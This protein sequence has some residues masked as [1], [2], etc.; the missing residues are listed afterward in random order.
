MVGRMI[1]GI[2]AVLLFLP[3]CSWAQVSTSPGNYSRLIVKRTLFQPGL[4]L[5]VQGKYFDVFYSKPYGLK[6]L[7]TVNGTIIIPGKDYYNG[8][9]IK[10]FGGG[11]YSELETTVLGVYKISRFFGICTDL[12]YT[13]LE[14]KGYK[15]RNNLTYSGGGCL[16]GGTFQI[17]VM[18]RNLT[19]MGAG[20]LEERQKG[21][22]ISGKMLLTENILFLLG[23]LNEES[24]RTVFSFES[25]LSI[26]A[27]LAVSCGIGSNPGEYLLGLEIMGKEM[28]LTYYYRDHTDLGGTFELGI[29]IILK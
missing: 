27:K 13:R 26:T 15:D 3:V 8:I 2:I 29:S 9:S 14:I 5:D 23:I 17:G 4:I 22:H 19:Q 24:R 16:Y 28:K 10:K 20:N 1:T 21:L 12:R 6:E 11:S 18:A 7:E 25:R